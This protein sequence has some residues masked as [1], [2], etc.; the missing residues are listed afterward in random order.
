MLKILWIRSLSLSSWDALLKM[1]NV[2]LELISDTDLYFFV[3]KGMIDGISYIAN[4]YS[5]ANNK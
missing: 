3:E 1:T 5:K 2:K 4:R